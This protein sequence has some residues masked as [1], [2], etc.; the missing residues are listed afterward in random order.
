MED[1]PTYTKIVDSNQSQILQTQTF[2][3]NNDIMSNWKVQQ[4]NRTKEET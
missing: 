3:L 1:S 4:S 2:F